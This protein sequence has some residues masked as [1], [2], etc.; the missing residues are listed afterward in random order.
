MSDPAVFR[1]YDSIHDTIWHSEL[2]ASLAILDAG[3]NL[4]SLMLRYQARHAPRLMLPAFHVVP[5]DADLEILV[6]EYRR[7]G[8]GAGCSPSSC[9]N[10]SCVGRGLARSEILDL[11]CWVRLP[12]RP[13]GLAFMMR[14]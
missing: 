11:Q 4:D 12:C 13:A 3:Y 5:E 10:C 1:C 9:Q 6:M 8:H 14:S 2:G 7:P